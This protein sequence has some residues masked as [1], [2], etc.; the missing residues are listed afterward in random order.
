MCYV[1]QFSPRPGLAGSC[2]RPGGLGSG[3]GALRPAETCAHLAS[4][5][6]A[7]FPM[8]SFPCPTI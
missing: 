4:D 6:L 5:W 1:W 2:W 3:D 7:G 8:V